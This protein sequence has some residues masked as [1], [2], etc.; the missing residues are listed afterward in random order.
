MAKIDDGPCGSGG[1]AEDEEGGGDVD[2]PDA[3]IHEP[4]GALVFQDDAET[5]SSAVKRCKGVAGSSAG[6]QRQ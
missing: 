2:S 4:L 5:S 3:R 6:E 1:A